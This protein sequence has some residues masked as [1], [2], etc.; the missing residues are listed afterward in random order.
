MLQKK[1]LS[2]L[3]LNLKQAVFYVGYKFN[4]Y[5]SNYMWKKVKANAEKEFKTLLE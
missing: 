5:K 3:N 2:K 4:I 1:G